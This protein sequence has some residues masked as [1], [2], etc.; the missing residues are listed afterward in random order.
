M[1]THRA[2]P[3]PQGLKHTA[4]CGARWPVS[5]VSRQDSE[6]QSYWGIQTSRFIRRTPD[7]LRGGLDPGGAGRDAAGRR[8]Q[9]ATTTRQPVRGLKRPIGL[10]RSAP[11]ERELYTALE[12][13]VSSFTMTYSSSSR[14]SMNIASALCGP[15]S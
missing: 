2:L 14:G 10:A 7:R 5:P 3:A 12:G 4:S 11:A 1:C 13:A 8:P 15:S 6:V 9:V